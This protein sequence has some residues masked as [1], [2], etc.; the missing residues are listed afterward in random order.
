MKEI[1]V[2]QPS[3]PD[4]GEFNELLSDIWDRKILTNN[5]YYHQL[6][7]EQ[8]AEY[9]NVKYVSLFSNG[10]LALMVAL[11]VLNIEGEV[12][13]TPYS[14]VATSHSILWNGCKPV[15]CDTEKDSYNIDAD[16]IESLITSK[17]TAIMPV[18]V[19]GIP[20]DN[21]KIEAI[22]KKHN[23]KVI[24]DAAHAFGVEKNGESIL[25]YGDLSILS[26]HATKVFNTIEGGAIISHDI[27]TKNK[28][29][30]L[31][32]FGIVDETTIEACG[33][34]AK[35]NEL[36]AAFG[37]LQLKKIHRSIEKRKM[38][39]HKYKLCLKGI[40][41]IKLLDISE[42]LN[43][44]YSYFPISIDVE[45][46]N[47][48]RDNLYEELKE[49]GVFARKYF[50]PLISD[51]EVYKNC[52]KSDLSQAKLISDNVL[53]LPLYENLTDIDIELIT[54]IIWSFQLTSTKNNLKKSFALNEYIVLNN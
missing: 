49:N 20:C 3:L 8:L 13:T 10:T 26:F 7:E 5:G 25:N 35:M 28:I 44:N 21:R 18:H 23:L 46:Y 22:A 54:G 37:L 34:N 52:R 33:I 48:S 30:K 2:T 17:T 6:L 27:E 4:L 12:I 50:Y 40:K 36:Q 14:F 29:D 9:L 53:C 24:Y 19:Y 42:D 47:C 32:N 31:K 1:Y 38:V 51:F 41:G 39:F 45:E 43:Y 11:K 16:K 15:F